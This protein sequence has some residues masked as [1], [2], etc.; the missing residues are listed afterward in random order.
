MTIEEASALIKKE[1]LEIGFS[2]CGISKAERVGQD[3]IDEYEYWLEKGWAAGM[4]YMQ[5]NK[6]L[7]YDPTELQPGAK[8]LI[9]VAMNYYPE[10]ELDSNV[11]FAYYSY[12]KDYHFVVKSYLALLL[13]YIEEYIS[14]YLCPNVV[15]EGRAFTDSA[16]ILER[17]WA[18]KSGVG[19]QGRNSLIIVPKVGSFCFLG[20]LAVNIELSYDSPISISCGNCHRC[21]ETC[22][23]HAICNRIVDA[24]KCIS[25]Q[26]IENRSENI[27]EDI[28]CK[29]GNRVFGCDACQKACPWNRF[30]TPTKVKE[31]SPSEKLMNITSSSI[32]NMD[33]QEFRSVF[34]DSAISR[35]GLKGLQ[36][37]VSY[38]NICKAEIAE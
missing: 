8:S 10:K 15:L 35:A 37:N 7:R 32:L 9:C 13:K 17:Y 28:S 20:I 30:V 21:E 31:F 33:K 24:N 26:T 29:L 27:P 6:T 25:Y 3:A 34:G 1:A 36:R 16:P 11:S 4:D 12:G 5:K 2:A 18:E 38:S 19:F 23:T 22:P 14:P